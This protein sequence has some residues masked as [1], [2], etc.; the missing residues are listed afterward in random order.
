MEVNF[1][2]EQEKI[3][4]NAQHIV[5]TE[6]ESDSCRSMQSVFRKMAWFVTPLT[7][8][9]NNR[10]T[11][12]IFFNGRPHYTCLKSLLML[13]KM[14]A[15]QH[16]YVSSRQKPQESRDFKVASSCLG[17]NLNHVHQVLV[18]KAN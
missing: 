2:L 13:K 4:C 3:P 18:S 5:C 16:T 17:N 8:L 9:D 12:S 6:N 14:H 7:N 11:I 15:I 10:P 1:I